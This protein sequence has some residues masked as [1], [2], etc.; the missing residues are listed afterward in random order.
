MKLTIRRTGLMGLTLLAAVTGCGDDTTGA[1]GGGGG[2][3]GTTGAATTAVTSSA[4]TTVAATTAASTAST[5]SSDGGGGAGDG[6]S[7]T[8]AQGGSS[9]DG[10]GGSNDGGSSPG[11]TEI[12]VDADG[13]LAVA[14]VQL[15]RTFTPALGD[16][17]TIDG[18]GFRYA[19]AEG[20][21]ELD[22]VVNDNLATCDQCVVVLEDSDGT[23]AGSGRVYFQSGG[24]LAVTDAEAYPIAALSLTGVT[25]VEVT[26]DDAFVSTP[27]PGGACLVVADVD[28]DFAVP[29]GWTC[30][31]PFYASADGCDCECGAPDPDCS[32]PGEERLYGCGSSGPPGDDQPTCSAAGLCVAPVNWTCPAEVFGDGLT[33]DCACG[34]NDPDCSVFGL[35]IEGCDAGEVCRTGSCLAIPP[36]WTCNSGFYAANDGCDCTCGVYDPDCD[37]GGTAFGCAPGEGCTAE[38]ECGVPAQWT[39]LDGAYDD[40]VTCDCTC[41]FTDPDCSIP[42]APITGCEVDEICAA[43]ACVLPSAN[44]QCVNAIV[45]TEGT[46]NGTWVNSTNDIDP[47]AAGCTGFPEVGGD[48]F[49]S[50]SLTTGQTLTVSINQV[51]SAA[52]SALYLVTDCTDADTCVAGVDTLPNT[53]EELVYNATANEDLILVVDQYGDTNQVGFVLTVDIQ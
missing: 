8:S 34:V 20:D 23:F 3:A 41:G 44:D 10:G 6:G 42:G 18:L 12:T 40:G 9:S 21:F 45:L 50:V 7:I 11:C 5:S 39:C 28:L 24:T 26:V 32:V 19:N 49:Y 30:P 35:P 27:V 51:G 37:A 2:G 25:L 17:D 14:G 31:A 29:E 16:A 46:V 47:T 36:E 22:S 13:V 4:A 52:D 43:G 38:G 33:C 15:A 1:G 53:A 48:V